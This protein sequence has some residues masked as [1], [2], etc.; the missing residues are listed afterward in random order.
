MASCWEGGGSSE[1]LANATAERDQIPDHWDRVRGRTLAWASRG[2]SSPLRSGDVLTLAMQAAQSLAR[3]RRAV[4]IYVPRN[5]AEAIGGVADRAAHLHHGDPMVCAAGVQLNARLVQGGMTES[6]ASEVMEAFDGQAVAVPMIWSQTVIGLLAVSLHSEDR[7]AVLESQLVVLAEQ[8]AVSLRLA[9]LRNADWNPA[10]AGDKSSS[11]NADAAPPSTDNWVEVDGSVQASQ[12]V[13]EASNRT[14]SGERL[15][16]SPN[17]PAGPV[18]FDTQTVL[19]SV[20]HD[21][22]S[23]LAVVDMYC[24]LLIDDGDPS[25][26]VHLHRMRLACRHVEAMIRNLLDFGR[27]GSG[28]SSLQMT[29]DDPTET[30]REAAELSLENEANSR[31]IRTPDHA[32]RQALFDANVLRQVL[33]NLMTNALKFTGEDG[34]IEVRVEAL[35]HADTGDRD[36]VAISV[37][38]NGPGI[39]PESLQRIFEPYY[40]TTSADSFRGTGLGLAISHALVDRMGGV[41]RV[42]SEVGVGSTFTV[43]LPSA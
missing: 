38:D 11:R 1:D 31:T 27:L 37:R 5:L 19:S 42:D 34:I 18:G 29:L 15:D 20:A 22:R 3:D 28:A 25:T 12:N 32:G 26:H 9:L 8:V 30:I 24:Q 14:V 13:L 23:P 35:N 40:R 4:L 7:P 21:L 41:L 17:D 6:V 43:L 10:L 39:E 16:S 33:I 36:R 2:L